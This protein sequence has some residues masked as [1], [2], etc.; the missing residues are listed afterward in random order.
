MDCMNCT[1]NIPPQW[2]SCIQENKCP[3]CGKQIMDD[4]SKGLLDEL[5]EAMARMPNDPEGLAG[6]LLSNYRLQKIGDAEPT[7]FHQP[8]HIQPHMG[9]QGP[10]AGLPANVKIADNPVHKFLQRTG[11]A[12]QLDNRKRLKDLV[13]EIDG[14]VHANIYQEDHDPYIDLDA[15]APM[16][17]EYDYPP[18]HPMQVQ[19]S[20]PAVPVAKQAL[21]NSVV[22]GG[23]GP[24][25]PPTQE[26]IQAMAAAVSMAG[27][28][29]PLDGDL[30][31]ALQIDRMKRLAQQQAIASGGGNGPFRRSG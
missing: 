29:T 1:A 11:Y 13:S 9:A 5:R 17:D 20:Q 24:A 23:E 7:E 6:W 3:S 18:P 28:T 22:M 15:E 14:N 19:E 12:K 16:M 27:Q 8:R 25:V 31:P 2:V 26:E 4:S 21:A 10:N 30:P